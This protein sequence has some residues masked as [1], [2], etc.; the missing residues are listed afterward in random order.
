MKRDGEEK[1]PLTF[2]DGFCLQN[3]RETKR[4]G[5]KTQT[6][7]IKIPLSSR[8]VFSLSAVDDGNK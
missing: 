5:I 1:T 2:Y 8:K 3:S 7:V 6:L 4:K